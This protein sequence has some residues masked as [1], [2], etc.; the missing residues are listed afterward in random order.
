MD[1]TCG[2]CGVLP[3]VGD[4]YC[5][6]CGQ[7]TP[8]AVVAPAGAG[9]R[10]GTRTAHMTTNPTTQSGRPD[11]ET[12]VRQAPPAGNGWTAE[13]RSARAAR[14]GSIRNWLL[15]G[16][17]QLDP[18][19]EKGRKLAPAIHD[20]LAIASFVMVF[21]FGPGALICGILSLAEARRERRRASGLAVAAII[22]SVIEG[23]IVAAFIAFLIASAIFVNSQLTYPNGG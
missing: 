9:A 8:V 17:K 2:N 7:P 23:V 15:T 16:D 18:D 3:A 5:G 1:W 6:N 4:T 21:F 20:G 12:R 13:E 22:I 11:D 19:S 14:G 10:L